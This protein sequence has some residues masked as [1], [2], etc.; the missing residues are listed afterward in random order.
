[1]SDLL[2]VDGAHP[3]C[4]LEH[5]GLGPLHA[6]RALQCSGFTHHC[7]VHERDSCCCQSSVS[8][9]TKQEPVVAWRRQ[10]NIVEFGTNQ[11]PVV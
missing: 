3:V 7:E 10:P 8:L 9:E 1:M 2:G 6:K 4:E 11:Q 5:Q